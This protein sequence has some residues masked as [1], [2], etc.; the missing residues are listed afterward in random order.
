M[1][2]WRAMPPPENV[3]DPNYDHKGIVE[4]LKELTES[5]DVVPHSETDIDKLSYVKLERKIRL[6]K[7]KWGKFS[8]ETEAR[9]RNSPE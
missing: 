6:R 5:R 4:A 7:G 3:D 2:G 9:I 1:P 8:E